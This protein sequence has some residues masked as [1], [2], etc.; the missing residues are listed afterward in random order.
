MEF[1]KHDDPLAISFVR[2]VK[3]GNLDALRRL[4]NEVP[5]L[6]SKRAIDN[7]GVLVLLCTWLQ[8]GLDT[9][10]TAP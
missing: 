6:A 9:I 10:Q 2:A 7:K 3:T 4:L 8:I 1:I 5:G